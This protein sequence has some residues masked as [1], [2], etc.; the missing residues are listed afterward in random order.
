LKL[1]AFLVGENEPIF[2]CLA[3]Y[4]ADFVLFIRSA[5]VENITEFFSYC[6]F[7]PAMVV[8]EI[9]ALPL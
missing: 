6:F 5:G 4:G 2:Y 9:G 7:I 3:Q 8:N 1:L